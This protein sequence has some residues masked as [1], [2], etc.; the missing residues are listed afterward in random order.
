MPLHITRGAASAKAFGFTGNTAPAVPALIAPLGIV[1]QANSGG[2]WYFFNVDTETFVALP[3][4]AASASR[5]QFDPVSG[6]LYTQSDSGGSTQKWWA[7]NS[8]LTNWDYQGTFT[9]QGGGYNG[10]NG[11]GWNSANWNSATNGNST[12]YAVPAGNSLGGSPSESGSGTEDMQAYGNIAY[13]GN[14]N[15]WWATTMTSYSSVVTQNSLSGMSDWGTLCYDNRT[16]LFMLSQYNATGAYVYGNKYSAGAYGTTF[17]DETLG[18]AQSY[19]SVQTSGVY[20]SFLM[21]VDTSV[22]GG[23]RSTYTYTQD[24]SDGVM[25]SGVSS[26]A[27]STVGAY[28]CKT[29][30]VWSY[31]NKAYY[32]CGPAGAIKVT[33]TGPYQLSGSPTFI[34]P[35]ATLAGWR[36]MRAT[37][38]QSPCYYFDKNLLSWSA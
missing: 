4:S 18:T 16:G 32:M 6:I 27:Y 1:I 21:P 5:I 25:K 14:Y 38:G 2:T 26:G 17:T 9:Q 10:V 23:N 37:N 7:P 12:I 28:A 11:W 24:A 22:V 15:S 13:R 19:S 3:N 20:G 29:S 36:G 34:S 30:W 35:P 8:S 33:M 31:K